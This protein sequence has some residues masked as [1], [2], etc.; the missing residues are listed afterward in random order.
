[1]FV[2]VGVR[3]YCSFIIGGILLSGRKSSKFVTYLTL[4]IGLFLL[5]AVYYTEL[6]ARHYC[7]G[8]DIGKFELR[9]F[10]CYHKYNL[11]H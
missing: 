4:C 9:T 2:I 10:Y 1:M 6:A 7:P 8:D 11:A 3:F 5:E